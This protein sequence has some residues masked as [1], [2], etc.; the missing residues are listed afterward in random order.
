[1]KRT[2]F[3][4]CLMLAGCTGQQ[5]QD[6]MRKGFGRVFNPRHT[7]ERFEAICAGAPFP[8]YG[9]CIRSE[10]VRDNPRWRS[11]PHADLVD[12][13]L[14]WL[15]AA[16]AR[17]ADGRME[18]SDARLGA[19]EMKVRLKSIASERATNASIQQQAALSRMLAGLAIMNASVPQPGPLIQCRTTP[20]G[21]G[22]TMTTCH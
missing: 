10:L 1:M 9:S 12:V 18:E 5:T 17:V 6:A 8:D 21:L 11:D 22:T 15:D 7:I 4:A 3:L 2:T 16:G 20:T 19:A 13:Y 14:A